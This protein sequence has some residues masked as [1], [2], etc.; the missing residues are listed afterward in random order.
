MVTVLIGFT[1]LAVDG[2]EA[3]AQHQLVRNAADGAALA[4]AYGVFQAGTTT[5]AATVLAGDVISADQLAVGDLTMTYLDSG[6]APTAVAASVVTV[7]AAVSDSEPTFF[8][9]M[10]GIR[11]F[12]VAATAEARS[13]GGGSAAC[14]LCSMAASGAGITSAPG[15]ALSVTGGGVVVD[16]TSAGNITLGNNAS[17]TAPAV[18]IA[19]GSASLGAGA[20]I[21]PAPAVGAVQADPFPTLAAPSLGGSPVAYTAAGGTPTMAPGLYSTITVPSGSALIMSPGTYVVTRGLSVTGGSLSGSGVTIFLACAAY[22]TP[23]V[24][25]ATGASISLTTGSITLTP[26][27][28]GSYAGLTV[29][30]DRGNAANS[31]LGNVTTLSIAGTWYGLQSGITSTHA[32]D[33]LA[34]GQLVVATLALA[35]NQVV[36][37][38][39]SSPFYANPTTVRLSL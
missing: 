14:A 15:T 32:G 13:A 19:G 33:G 30:A 20:T 8:L 38:S 6:G 4:A 35:K 16:S 7:R 9:G 10:L 21:T 18:I 3:E 29:F 1:G 34:F 37:V 28:T 22:P 26:P 5:V 24:S 12:R 25:G 31:S 23:C 27:S 17:L 36:T 2:G 11:T 39:R